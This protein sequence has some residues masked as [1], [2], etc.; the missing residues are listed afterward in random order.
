MVFGNL[1][2]FGVRRVLVFFVTLLAGAV[3]VF[4]A[5]KLAPGDPALTALGES[6]KP[7]LVAA[8]RHAHRLDLPLVAQFGLWLAGAAHGD[9]GR[10]LTLAGGV[11]VALLI[12][13][14]LP[15]TV[16]V[17]LYALLLAVVISLVIGTVSALQRGRLADT[18]GTSFAVLGVSMP[19]FWLGYVLIFFLALNFPIFPSYGFV[20]P[21]VSLP[22]ALLSGFLPA[23]AIAAP[24]AAVFARTLRAALLEVLHREYVTVA[25]SIGFAPRFVFLHYVLR[26]ALIPYVTVL[27]LQV[28]YLLGGVVVI[29]R[30][31]GIPGMGSLMVDAAFGRDYPVV[32][33][34]ALTFLLIVL[35]TNLLVD[36]VCGQLDPRRAA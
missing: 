28:R 2:R 4:F 29:E 16:F 1:A 34:C 9:F 20:S 7:E 6:A 14:R 36:T 22:G 25:R 24:M 26:N 11:P 5:M 33:A 17:G 8:F 32:Q 35:L 21:V 27:G 10:S 18:I 13:T 19:D 12:G 3:A 31:F 15:V 23:L 30:I